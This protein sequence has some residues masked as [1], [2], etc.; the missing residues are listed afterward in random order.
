MAAA[1]RRLIEDR[2]AAERLAQRALADVG[3]YTWRRRAERIAALLADVT[4]R[5]R[6]ST[7]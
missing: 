2:A 3:A 7:L 4:D 5:S 6:A 1:I